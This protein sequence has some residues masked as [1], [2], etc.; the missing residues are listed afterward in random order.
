M[1]PHKSFP[2]QF[3]FKIL[4][5]FPYTKNGLIPQM[6]INM[7]LT[8][9]KIYNIRHFCMYNFS[10]YLKFQHFLFSLTHFQKSTYR[11]R[12]ILFQPLFSNDLKWSI[13]KRLYCKIVICRNQNHHF[14]PLNLFKLLYD[15]YSTFYRHI[16]IQYHQFVVS[17]YILI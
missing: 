4:H 5:I 14:I 1:C 7:M 10:F 11:F 8:F 12:Q 9:F 16:Q 3:F 15:I 17:D 6:H 13:R 2:C